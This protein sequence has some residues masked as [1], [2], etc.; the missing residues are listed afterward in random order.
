MPSLANPRAAPNTPPDTVPDAIEPARSIGPSKAVKRLESQPAGVPV[1]SVASPLMAPVRVGA[2][3]IASPMPDAML[4]DI[5]NSSGMAITPAVGS[6]GR[7]VTAVTPVAP[8]VQLPR[9]GTTLS[10]LSLALPARF[11][12]PS[13][14]SPATLPVLDMAWPVP[15]ITEPMR[16]PILLTSLPPGMPNGSDGSRI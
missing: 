14:A 6:H 12:S 8:E 16:W 10:A 5:S 9:P 1:R 4:P 13:L 15:S 7:V 11:L 3:F 2:F